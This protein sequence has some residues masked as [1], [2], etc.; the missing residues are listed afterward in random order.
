MPWSCA[1]EPAVENREWHWGKIL[2]KKEGSGAQLHEELRHLN[3]EEW[4]LVAEATFPCHTSYLSCGFACTCRHAA[5]LSSSSAP[6][7]YNCEWCWMVNYLKLKRK[8]AINNPFCCDASRDYSE[9]IN[10]DHHPNTWH[11]CKPTSRSPYRRS[12]TKD[13]SGVMAKDFSCVMAL[14]IY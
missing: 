4:L 8:L 7:K 6:S 12:V 2:Y 14:Q 9:S 13:L 1:A 11:T 10:E 5:S 3:K